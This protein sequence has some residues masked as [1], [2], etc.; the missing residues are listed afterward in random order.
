MEG[1]ITQ[2]APGRTESNESNQPEN[3]HPSPCGEVSIACIFKEGDALPLPSLS[4]KMWTHT[5]SVLRHSKDTEVWSNDES[6][7]HRGLGVNPDHPNTLPSP[8]ALLRYKQ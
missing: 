5:L 3:S 6:W 4:W 8:L 1:C 2:V 7:L